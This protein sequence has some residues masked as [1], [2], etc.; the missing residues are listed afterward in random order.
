M[1]L[2]RLNHVVA[3]ADTL[4]FARAAEAAHLSQPAF[5]RSRFSFAALRCRDDRSRRAVVGLRHHARL[6]CHTRR[7]VA[8]HAARAPRASTKRRSRSHRGRRQ[9]AKNSCGNGLSSEWRK[10]PRNGWRKSSRRSQNRS[11]RRHA[12]AVGHRVSSPGAR[13]GLIDHAGALVPG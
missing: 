6:L 1:N 5:S 7:T 4:H 12:G 11:R 13:F 3:L 9:R 2:R 10:R 8:A